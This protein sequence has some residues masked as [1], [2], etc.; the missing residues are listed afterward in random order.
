MF[1]GNQ[2]WK[3]PFDAIVISLHHERTNIFLLTDKRQKKSYHTLW[4]FSFQFCANYLKSILLPP[5]LIPAI[6]KLPSETSAPALP[7]CPLRKKA[8]GPK[9]L[10]A[11]N[12]AKS[13]GRPTHA[14]ENTRS[15]RKE[16]RICKYPL[17]EGCN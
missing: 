4:S 11:T 3:D 14:A 15:L 17:V 16:S 1:T 12:A 2:K 5:T 9:I 7:P 6:V 10:T 13:A 8:P